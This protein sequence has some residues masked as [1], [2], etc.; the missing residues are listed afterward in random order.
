MWV[1]STSVRLFWILGKN[2]FR[3][4]KSRSWTSKT[5]IVRYQWVKILRRNTKFNTRQIDNDLEKNQTEEEGEEINT[6]KLSGFLKLKP[7][8]TKMS[9]PYKFYLRSIISFICF[10]L[11]LLRLFFLWS[12]WMVSD[13]FLVLN[14]K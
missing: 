3:G 6:E 11:R 9:F 10:C 5:D 8:D 1:W 14:D 12:W 2:N 4:R 13:G 7:N